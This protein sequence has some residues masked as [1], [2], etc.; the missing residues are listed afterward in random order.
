MGYYRQR[1]GGVDVQMR[2]LCFHPALAPYRVDFFN[3]LAKRTDLKLVLMLK[4]LRTQSFEQTSLK[5]QLEIPVEYAKAI[6]IKGRDIPIDVFRKVRTFNPDVI[7]TYECSPVT[8]LMVLFK[9]FFRRDLSVWSFFDDSPDLIRRRRG[10]RRIVCNWTMRNLSGVIVPS[11]LAIDAYKSTVRGVDA[12][13]FAVVPIVHDVNVVRKSE[14]KVFAA[15]GDW[16][17]KNLNSGEKAA[18]FVGRMTAVKNLPWLLDCASDVR[19]PK[20]VKLFLV[21]SGDQETQLQSKISTQRLSPQVTMLGRR[22]GLALHTFFAAQDL[23]ILPSSAEPFGAVVSE[24]LQWGAPVLVSD[25]VGA[26]SLVH[27]G[28]NGD[29]F[30]CN[31]KGDFFA[32][33]SQ[34]I[35]AVSPWTSGRPSLEKVDLSDNVVKLSDAFR[36]TSRN[37]WLMYHQTPKAGD[38]GKFAVRMDRFKEQM[39][40]IA[41]HHLSD[42]VTITFDDG[43]KSNYDA[44][45]FMESLGLKGVFYILKDKSL[46]DSDYLSADQIKRISD[47]GHVIGIH[48]KDHKWW[49][50]KAPAQLIAELNE[51]KGWIEDVTGKRVE[52][53]SVPGGR[54]NRKVMETIKSGCSG[55]SSIRTSIEDYNVGIDGHRLVNA[56]AM[57]HDMSDLQFRQILTFR[58]WCYRQLRTLYWMKEFV[59]KCLLK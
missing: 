23:F 11:H 38:L 39:R 30:E 7:L 22:E 52:H 59:K 25:R 36:R 14:A 45:E 6:A 12:L 34:I 5:A 42:R 15:A 51:V 35:E 53:C 19:W 48:G 47:M 43:H 41:E 16:R 27:F 28:V 4:N 56:V 37:V 2:V 29:V 21:G 1:H 33:F 13:H 40:F 49:T 54:F 58:P 3:L 18:F 50:R 44:A 17:G 26:K 46:N 20:N 32:K 31:N 10:L 55:L 9:K 57:R 24:S 8:L